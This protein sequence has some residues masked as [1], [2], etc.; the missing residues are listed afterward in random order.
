MGS[1][2]IENVRVFDGDRL[3]EPRRVFVVDGLISDVAGPDSEIIDADGGALLPG[4][5]DGHVHVDD[6]KQATTLAHWGVTTALDMGAK[7]PTVIHGLRGTAGVADVRTA[8]FLAAPLTGTHIARLGYPASVAISTPGEAGA[9]V[10]AR[11][12]D[13]SDYIKLLLEPTLPGQP[14]PLTPETAAAIVTAAHA[15][16]KKVI[17]HTT[18]GTTAAIAVQ[19]GVDAITHTPLGEVLSEEF[20]NELQTRGVVAIPTL[21][22]MS[23]MANNWPFPVRPPTVDFANALATIAR[24]HGKGV[25]IVA[26]TDSNAHPSTPAQPPHGEAL[27][28]ELELMVAAGL[29]PVEALRAATSNAAEFFG[30]TD[31][32]RV[33]P[34][35]RADLVLVDGNPTSDISATRSI[36]GV[37]IAGERVR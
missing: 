21:S 16:G 27:H 29:T 1:F 15:A 14:E 3:S 11:V 25:A 4:L 10:S 19:A 30:L 7:D 9:W 26:G 6:S 5:I 2:S 23:A 20:A 12:A 13:G 8:G 35:L 17:A 37:W 34:G 31:R 18:T 28:G 33:T 24:F 36:R 22:L 32:G